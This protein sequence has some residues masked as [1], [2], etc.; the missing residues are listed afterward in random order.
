MITA[1]FSMYIAYHAWFFY[2]KGVG[3]RRARITG[4]AYGLFNRGK[5]ARV[6]FITSVCETDDTIL[7]IQQGRNALQGVSF[8]AAICTLL[9]SQVLDIL[10]DLDKQVRTTDMC[11]PSI[12]VFASVADVWGCVCRPKC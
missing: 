10:L 7:G 6:Q 2:I 8:L 5:I 3:F 12:T 11:T 9:A 1:S 4:G